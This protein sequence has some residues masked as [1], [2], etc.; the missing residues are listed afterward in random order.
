[1]RVVLLAAILLALPFGGARA[2]SPACASAHLTVAFA[3]DR[4]FLDQTG[5]EALDEFLRQA[6]VCTIVRA[7]VVGHAGR[8]EDERTARLRAERMRDALR[9]RG[10]ALEIITMRTE[11]SEAESLRAV[12]TLTLASP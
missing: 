7:D 12:I 6:R 4:A 11:L 1:M 8:G 5:L 10:L 9:F 3:F 2:Q